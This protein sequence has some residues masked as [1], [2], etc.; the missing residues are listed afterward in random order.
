MYLISST[1][2]NIF[3]WWRWVDDVGCEFFASVTSIHWYSYRNAQIESPSLAKDAVLNRTQSIMKACAIVCHYPKSIRASP[4]FGVAIRAILIHP[5]F[6]NS[7]TIALST[8]TRLI[9]TDRNGAS[10]TTRDPNLKLDYSSSLALSCITVC[11]L[12]LLFKWINLNI[13]VIN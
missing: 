8:S 13:R 1:L 4:K 11:G 10:D 5:P 7:Y 12:I 3:R 9:W 6:L 2:S